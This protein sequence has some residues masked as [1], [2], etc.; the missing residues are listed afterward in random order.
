MGCFEKVLPIHVPGKRFPLS[1]PSRAVW[2]FPEISSIFGWC[3][4]SFA[5]SLLLP[6][7]DRKSLRTNVI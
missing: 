3:K 7:S 4:A 6:Y 5:G 2:G 1:G